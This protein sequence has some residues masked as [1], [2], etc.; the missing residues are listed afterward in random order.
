MEVQADVECK[1]KER[2]GSGCSSLDEASCSSAAVKGASGGACPCPANCC[3]PSPPWS[4]EPCTSAGPRGKGKMW[5]RNNSKESKSEALDAQLLEQRS[6]NS[7]EF[8]SP[9]LSGSLPSVADS[10]CSHFSSE[11]S[12]CEPVLGHS[13]VSDRHTPVPEE[14]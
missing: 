11:L 9:S 5:K 4:K 6:T 13:A 7:S 3:C 1:Q 2:R 10:H 12:C 8:D 14:Q